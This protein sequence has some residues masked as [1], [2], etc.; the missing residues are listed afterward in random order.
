MDIEGQGQGPTSHVRFVVAARNAESGSTAPLIAAAA[1]GAPSDSAAPTVPESAAEPKPEPEPASKGRP[2]EDL[3]A[4]GP[5]DRA[6]WVR[7]SP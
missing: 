5:A 7:R 1:I 6:L 3:S 4:P 2:A